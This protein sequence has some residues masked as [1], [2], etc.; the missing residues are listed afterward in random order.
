ML[1]YLWGLLCL[2]QRLYL[3]LGGGKVAVR[4]SSMAEDGNG[5]SFAGLY[6]TYLNVSGR[7]NVNTAV[8]RVF[9]SINNPAAKEYAAINGI[10]DTRMAVIVQKMIPAEYAGVIFTKEPVMDDEDTMCVEIVQGLGDKLVSGEVT[11]EGYLVNKR[12]LEII[13]TMTATPM[14]DPFL[15]KRI[16][17]IGKNIEKHF[18]CSQDIE[19]CVAESAI[20]VSLI[21]LTAAYFIA[22]GV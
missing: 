11:P 19:F 21:S 17:V 18:G 16:A 7:D 6:K 8:E 14:T 3:V 5:V 4:S 15:I 2:R 1:C 13:D 9:N 10:R 12:T 22:A 20:F